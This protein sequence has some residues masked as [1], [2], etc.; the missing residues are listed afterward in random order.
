MQQEGYCKNQGYNPVD[1]TGYPTHST[2]SYFIKFQQ[3]SLFL[4]CNSSMPLKERKKRGMVRNCSKNYI[5]NCII[6]YYYWYTGTLY[7]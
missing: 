3:L 1:I 2:R 5:T 7:S 4:L 6:I